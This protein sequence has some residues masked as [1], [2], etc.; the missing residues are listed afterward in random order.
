MYSFAT[1]FSMAMTRLVNCHSRLIVVIA[2]QEEFHSELLAC[3]CRQ[4]GDQDVC[5]SAEH[6]LAGLFSSVLLFL[7]DFDRRKRIGT[8][9]SLLNQAIAA[10]AAASPTIHAPD[11]VSLVVVSGR[12]KVRCFGLNLT[13]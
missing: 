6:T 9:E 12:R 8:N 11:D 3:S 4:S 10:L 1:S 7:G 13:A 5:D 2:L